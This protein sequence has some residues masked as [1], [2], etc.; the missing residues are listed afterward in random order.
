MS[1][2]FLNE[3]DVEHFYRSNIE[4]TTGS[5]FTSPHKTDGYIEWAN[6]RML[7]E[8]KYS[9]DL[10]TNK[11]RSSV[12]AQALYYVKKFRAEGQSPNVIFVGDKSHC[13]ALNI[14]Q[15]EQFLDL[16]IDWSLAPSTPD[17][18][19]ETAISSAGISPFVDSL[20]ANRF[21]ELIASC[22][23]LAKGS[24]DKVKATPKTI[25][26][27]F[28]YW[29]DR[30]F[31]KDKSL[32]VSTMIDVFFAVLFHDENE[33][34]F[35]HPK[36]KNTLI[37]SATHNGATST[38]E[39]KL[40]VESMQGFF[41]KYQRGY[42]PSEIDKL[43]S[44]R[45]RL[46]DDTKRRRNGEFYTPADWVDEAHKL[47]QQQL[48]IECYDDAVWID[49]CCGVANLTRDY[50]ITNLAL[51]T[52][53]SAD[54][55]GIKRE[56]YNE[57]G[58]IFQHDFLNTQDIPSEMDSFLKKASSE[59]KRIIFIMN[60]PYATAGDFDPDV[61]SKAGVAL[62]QTNKDMKAFDLG[63]ASQQL[64]AQFIFK[65]ELV[66]D[67]YGFSKKTIAIFCKPTFMTSGSFDSF[68]DFMY[69]RYS[70]NGGFL[71]QASNFADVSGAWGISFTLWSE[72]STS[73]TQDIALD[74]KQVTQGV[75]TTFGTK[76]LYTSKDKEA[77][78]WVSELATPSSSI[79]TPKF[80]SGLKLKESNDN[81]RGLSADSFGVLCNKA[82]NVMKSATDVYFLSGKPT[83]KP[84]AN[85]N[86]VSG[87]SWRRCIAL[88]SARK[89]VSGTWVNDKDEYLA[90][91]TQIQG[92]E[93]WVDDCH[94]YSLLHMSN[95]MTAM[96][97]VEYKGSKWTIDNHFFWLTREDALKLYDT[98]ESVSIF[99]DCKSSKHDPYF[100]KILP[101]LNLSPLAKEIMNDLN[102]L[103]K[104]TLALRNGQEERLHLTCWDAGIYQ[105][106]E[107]WR[108]DPRWIALKEKHR[109]LA[110]QLQHGVYTYGF[111][112]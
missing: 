60:P 6:V 90:P 92:Y 34:V 87:E 49:P 89:L 104:D 64:Y 108:E 16:P 57:G 56:G 80:S 40:D 8:A 29:R 69:S 67:K 43:M 55:E 85:I 76:V 30:I 103:L 84:C 22:E 44:Q 94:V 37:L 39:V 35:T 52:L 11:G 91:N 72:G 109:M 42:S 19:L 32:D 79:D 96:R 15:L 78:S 14:S 83:D 66:A 25:H 81:K 21:K 97:N 71:F 100:A 38:K 3:K 106:K 12:L 82:N 50:S 17:K 36:K 99:R 112:K 23:I 95:N 68:R 47:I 20:P 33:K 65:S 53:E 4:R 59:G 28:A 58:L 24:I 41:S 51:S 111:L 45:D 110:Q 107:I 5:R 27:M 13:F 77:S 48:G 70:Y 73:H 2:D 9:A 74:L 1:N 98:K 63:K 7:L 10:D 102:A 26:S 61:D 88:Y 93:Q 105:L 75:I 31:T 46:I 18:K 86:L 54:I 101:T 62:T